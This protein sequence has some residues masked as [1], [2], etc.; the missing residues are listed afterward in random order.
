[1]L[2]DLAA[3][4]VTGLQATRQGCFLWASD[5]IV[6]EFSEHDEQLDPAIKSSVVPFYEQQAT[7]F[8]HALSEVEGHQL[9]DLVEDFFRLSQSL[10]LHHTS[11][12]LRSR[13]MGDVLAAASHSLTL[14]KQESLFSTLHFLR[15]F[16]GYGSS[17]PPSSRLTDEPP[18][19]TSEENRQHIKTLLLVQ[20]QVITERVLT[21]MMYSF[22]E[23]C[24]PDASGVII[25]MLRVT[26]YPVPPVMAD[27]MVNLPGSR[28][29]NPSRGATLRRRY[30]EVKSWRVNRIL[31]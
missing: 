29:P 14:L 7:T 13:L 17:N 31:V 5:A 8:L 3:K 18:I 15:D 12:G 24:I 6:R 30:D 28:L 10:L 26:I 4:L 11:E 20:G 27:D 23:D 16:I 9:G 1:M 2:P 21:G 22:P 25:D 19:T